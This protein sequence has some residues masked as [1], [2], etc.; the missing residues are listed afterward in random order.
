MSFLNPGKPKY[1][2]RLGVSV[3]RSLEVIKRELEGWRRRDHPRE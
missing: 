2:P 1:G 3:A